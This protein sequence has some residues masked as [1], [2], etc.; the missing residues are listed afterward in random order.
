MR[1]TVALSLALPAALALATAGP[2]TTRHAGPEQSGVPSANV[3][4]AN[5]AT[6]ADP[7]TA[8]DATRP[9]PPAAENEAESETIGRS[10]EGDRE[11]PPSPDGPFE[12]IG[13]SD[14]GFVVAAVP[15]EG[16]I[17]GTGPRWRYTI[18]VEPATGF[19]VDEVAT[20]VRAALNDPR[21]WARTRSLEQVDDPRTARIRLLVGT[22]DTVDAL[23]ARAGLRTVGIYSCW[24]GTFAAL[25]GWRWEV[26]ANGF[27]A[28]DDY[29]TYLV[30]HEFGHG[31]GYG[32]VG[33][34]S[35]GQMAPVMMQQS[36]GLDG[37]L[38]N[39]WPFP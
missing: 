16:G 39:G 7:V 35:P 20:L 13:R 17:A 25:N 12:P 1:R 27:T 23:C 11:A 15:A 18:E 8:P 37:C 5:V 10:D 24:N 6:P 26:G 29:R 9:G 30:N 22:P 28:I 34:P 33:C 32:H 19:N 14:E 3:T 2:F 31:L 36:K 4:S 38:P 21:S